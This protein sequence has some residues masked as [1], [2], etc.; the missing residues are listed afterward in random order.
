MLGRLALWCILLVACSNAGYVEARTTRESERVRAIEQMERRLQS[1][2][3][4][5]RTSYPTKSA[6]SSSAPAVSSK[7]APLL[8]RIFGKIPSPDSSKRPESGLRPVSG[9]GARTT[10]TPTSKRPPASAAMTASSS[11]SSWFRPGQVREVIGSPAAEPQR[12]GESGRP[13]GEAVNIAP[14]PNRPDLRGLVSSLLSHMTLMTGAGSDD[15]LMNAG[16]YQF[17]DYVYEQRKRS[18]GSANRFAPTEEPERESSSLASTRLLQLLA[19]DAVGQPKPAGSAP[20]PQTKRESSTA[21]LGSV[22]EPSPAGDEPGLTLI[23]QEDPSPQDGETTTYQK[24]L[25]KLQSYKAPVPPPLRPVS[26]LDG[27]LK[28]EPRDAS[29]DDG[30]SGVLDAL[31]MD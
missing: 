31:R 15:S 14:V 18:G 12:G 21:L 9:K 11:S 30:R 10:T 25:E 20:S 23:V 6:P 13:V 1:S 8:E 22:A 17:E 28:T 26:G 27:L 7:P 16:S 3:S 29:V 24:A 4:A 19:Q 5:K 2:A